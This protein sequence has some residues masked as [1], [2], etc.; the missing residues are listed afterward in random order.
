[1]PDTPKY[2]LVNQE[3]IRPGMEERLNRLFTD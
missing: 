3:L 2:R 1:M